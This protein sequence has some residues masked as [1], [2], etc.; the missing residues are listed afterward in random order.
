MSD[1]LTL[2]P[3]KRLVNDCAAKMRK[4][5]A[6]DMGYWYLAHQPCTP[7]NKLVP[8]DLAVTL[9]FNSNAGWRAFASLAKHAEEVDFSGLPDKPLGETTPAERETIIELILTMVKWPGF[10]TS[11]AT[12]VLHKKRPHLI[13]VL[14]NRAIFE[15]YLNE[16][17]PGQHT[18]GNTVRD[19]NTIR[20]ALDA[21]VADL[22]DPGN[23]ATWNTLT[24]VD[25][26]LTR[27]EVL[28]MVLWMRFRRLEPL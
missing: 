26:L 28:D 16:H 7:P 8:E 14:D 24:S 21:I 9:A 5:K 12:K 19:P 23:A 1:S 6:D 2:S 17:W 13:P 22:N 20:A 18:V 15:S 11:L 27:I 3:S 4:F 10:A 25:P